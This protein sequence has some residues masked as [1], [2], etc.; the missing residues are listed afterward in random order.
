MD[1]AKCMV[2]IICAA[3][4]H[5][6]YI[7]E[8]LD[9]FVMQKTNFDYEV[10][11]NDDAS[12]DA[13]AEIICEYAR[14]YPDIIKPIYQTVNQYSQ[15]INIDREFLL[16]NSNGK[17]IACCE[18]DDYWTDPYKLQKQV[19][20]LEE[21]PEYSATAHNCF[22][23]NSKSEQIPCVY[24]VYRDYRAHTYT[25]E[26]FSKDVVYPGQTATIVYRRSAML[27]DSTEQEQDY[28]AIRYSN[29][30]KKTI[31]KL[32]LEGNIYC[33]EEKMS[34]Y[35][36]VTHEGDSWSAA[37]HGTNMSYKL[38]AVS[39]DFRKFVRKYGKR[40]FMNYYSTFHTGV[41]GIIKA[42]IKPTKQNQEVY[43][44]ILQEHG[45]F[46]GTM[47][48]MLGLAIISIP[49]YFLCEVERKKYDPI[50]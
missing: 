46:V 12:T 14:Q 43:N 40:S 3:Y 36:V 30:D 16:P 8:A 5:E 17:Y 38:H 26:R 21:N 45:G 13:T 47:I 22:F 32:L 23:V 18:G 41:A 42:V 24:P 48:Y 1:K 27:F 20:F 9:G 34:A 39:I 50:T 6:K 19:D 7:R 15:G 4:N 35:R 10:I 44:Q 49:L 33:F 37:N 28:Y 11:I 31:L 29:Q 2:S 25:M